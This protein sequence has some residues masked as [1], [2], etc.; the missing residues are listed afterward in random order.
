MKTPIFDPADEGELATNSATML[1]AD[2]AG[3]ESYWIKEVI[4]GQPIHRN[5]DAE[6]ITNGW[7]WAS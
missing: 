1:V 7:R 5:R 4:G 3:S 6:F 2:L